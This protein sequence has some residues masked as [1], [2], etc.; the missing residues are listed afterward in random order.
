MNSSGGDSGQKQLSVL[1]DLSSNSVYRFWVLMIHVPKPRK[2]IGY[3]KQR[4]QKGFVNCPRIASWRWLSFDQAFLCKYCQR[5]SVFGMETWGR[6]ELCSAWFLLTRVRALKLQFCAAFR[7]SG[8]DGLKFK[9]DVLPPPASMPELA[10]GS[11][12]NRK[13]SSFQI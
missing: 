7:L 1:L 3:Q 12:H 13:E 11:H 2:W 5:P 6:G 10:R 8:K 9:R 4:H